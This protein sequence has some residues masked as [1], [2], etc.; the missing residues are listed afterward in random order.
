MQIYNRLQ[1]YKCSKVL[2]FRYEKKTASDARS[3]WLDTAITQF[4]SPA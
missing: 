1:N 4:V 3:Y 2:L